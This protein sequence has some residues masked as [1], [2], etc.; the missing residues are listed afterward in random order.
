MLHILRHHKPP[1][2]ELS[3]APPPRID[4]RRPPVTP[5]RSVSSSSRHRIK[6]LSLKSAASDYFDYYVPLVSTP[7]T[8]NKRRAKSPFS[9]P[10]LSTPSKRVRKFKNISHLWEEE[11]VPVQVQDTRFKICARRL[12]K[13]AP[14]WSSASQGDDVV[15]LDDSGVCATDFEKLVDLDIQLQHNSYVISAKFNDVLAILRVSISLHSVEYIQWA[16]GYLEKWF[17]TKLVAFDEVLANQQPETATAACIALLRQGDDAPLLKSA[18]YALIC[19]GSEAGEPKSYSLNEEHTEMLTAHDHRQMLKAIR[20]LAALWITAAA[21]PTLSHLL[22]L[23]PTRA[24]TIRPAPIVCGY[25]RTGTSTSTSR[26]T[27]ST[28]M[29]RGTQQFE[30]PTPRPTPGPT[31]N[32][33]SRTCVS[34]DAEQMMCIHARLVHNSGMLRR[35]A[36]DPLRGLRAL[37]DLRWEDEGLCGACANARRAVWRAERERVWALMDGWFEGDWDSG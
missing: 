16:L 6:S 28:F 13:I 29:W 33:T 18:F 23:C 3:P 5:G 32:P 12:A 4:L 24:E 10:S 14:E 26:G 21:S 8:S 27:Q 2:R 17:P 1:E 22:P 9:G 11:G 37:A 7:P 19:R 15:Y 31:Y 30:P 35:F 25:P 36:C 34:H 20:E